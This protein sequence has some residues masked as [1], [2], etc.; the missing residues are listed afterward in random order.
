MAGFQ[1]RLKN[2]LQLKLSLAL[3]IAILVVAAIAGV[4]SFMTAFDE[5]NELQDDVLRQVAALVDRQGLPASGERLDGRPGD[6]DEESR[7]LVQQLG[8]KAA[9]GRS[10]DAGDPLVLPSSLADGLQTQTVDG[11]K[12]RVL[13]RTRGTGERFVVAQESGFRDQIARDGALRTVLPFLVLVPILLVITADLVRKLFRPMAT[14]AAEIDL[15][16]RPEPHPVEV[17]PLPSEVQPFAVAINGLLERVRASME[18]QQRFVAD[19]AHELRSP[20]TA[21]SLQAERLAGVGLDGPAALHLAELRRG[22]DRARSLLEQML[23]LAKAQSAAPVSDGKTNLMQVVKDVLQDLMPLA[24]E[25]SIDLGVSVAHELEVPLSALEA[26]LVVRNLV[27][28][29]IRY[30]P[31]GGRVD[32]L[33]ERREGEDVF[34]VRDSG[35][36]LDAQQIMRI[37]DPFYRVPGSG[38][39]GSGLGLTIVKSVADRH[40]LRLSVSSGAATDLH[41]LAVAIHFEAQGHDSPLQNTPSRKTA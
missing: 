9:D 41:G 29:A 12:F 6:G 21:L 31:A 7:V 19:A 26:T 16:E 35:A 36:G 17:A 10:V 37:F 11:E 32:I 27:D 15:R 13:I 28:N 8:A 30:T 39:S 24:D 22:I 14:L 2:S 3:S 18:A 40:G 33:L 5:A 1:G 34:A 25:Q 20:M 4:F 38:Q 23:T